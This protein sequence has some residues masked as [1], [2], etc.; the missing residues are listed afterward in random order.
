MIKKNT[1]Q[2][3]EI[4][5]I[6]NEVLLGQVIDT[7]SS[8][9]ASQLHKIGFLIFRRSAIPD[10]KDEIL[11][12]LKGALQRADLVIL[13]G[14]LGPTHD[15]ITKK[16][17]SAFLKRRL[18]LNE[19]VL[20]S[21]KSHFA[22][23]GIR[24]PRV[25]T[26]QALIPQ[27]AEILQNPIGT[28]PGLLFEE[29]YGTIIL[30]PGV[31]AEMKAIF[32]ESV[33]PYLVKKNN[34]RAIAVQTIHTTGITES[35]L[36]ERLH[37][38]IISADIA[39]LPTFTGVDI[40]LTVTSDSEKGARH[41]LKKISGTII[42]T[43]DDYYY[44]SDD[45]TLER[46]IG[47]LL[48]MRKKTVAAAESCTAGLLMKRITDVPGSSAYFL[49][50]IVSY[51]NDAKVK[52]LKVREKVLKLKGAVSPEV[53]KAMAQGIRTR[54]KSDLGVSITGIAGPGGET[55]HKSVG[56]V[57]VGFSDTKEAHALRFQFNG[58]RD[59]IRQQAAQAALDILRRKLL[60]LSIDSGEKA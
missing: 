11:F 52:L 55:E 30:L 23:R 54:M 13:T 43:V 56:L 19:K 8:F 15:D 48:S 38:I 49:G 18:I 10:L 16:T 39:F 6:G 4:I 14:G 2:K 40:R 31:P 35:S 47:I 37:G 44:G 7:N 33:V 42:D 60:G 27:G 26:S 34:R 28:A 5:A 24:M 25:N 45:E 3:A 53:A 20:L 12:C 51:S 17:V 29:P 1:I 58:T 21:V 9:I 50:G 22:R 36:Y 59:V 32:L 41:K 57:F 46:V